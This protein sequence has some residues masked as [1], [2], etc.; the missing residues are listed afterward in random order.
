[1]GSRDVKLFDANGIYKGTL[2]DLDTTTGQAP[3][4]LT[5]NYLTNELLVAVASTTIRLIKAV[6]LTTFVERDFSAS[7]ALNNTLKGLAMLTN[8]DL[9]VVISGGN[10]VEKLSGLTGTQITAGAW[11]KALQ[12]LGSGISAGSAGTFIH[13]STTTDVVRTYDAA[14]TQTG[15]VATGIVGTTDV[16]DCQKDSAGNIY[17]SYNGTTD[18]IRKMTSGLATTWSYSNTVLLSNPGGIAVRANGNVLALDQTH[19]YIVEIQAD[20]SSGTILGGDSDN[21][22]NS[23]QFILVVP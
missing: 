23:P 14:G 9:L 13:C 16:M 10:R 6:H 17:G 5:I 19:N 8:G 20:G 7:P 22:L 15:T 18:T 1:M 3:Y 11:P 4:G 2:L 12:T 21:M